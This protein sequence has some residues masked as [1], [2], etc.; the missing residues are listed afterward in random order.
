MGEGWITE[1]QATEVF[2]G[3]LVEGLSP[4]SILTPPPAPPQL[5]VASWQGWRMLC[6]VLA[7]RLLGKLFRK[8]SGSPG[9]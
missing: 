7:S 1:A 5:F 8:I 4:V 9:F 2:Q 6:G 3:R